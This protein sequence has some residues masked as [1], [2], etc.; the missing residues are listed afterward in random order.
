MI[1]IVS[2]LRSPPASKR[3]LGQMLARSC[4]VVEQ[5]DRAVLIALDLQLLAVVDDEARLVRIARR[6]VDE[7]VDDDLVSLAVDHR[8]GLGRLRRRSTSV[9]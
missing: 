9:K 2:G 3:A 7:I 5:R 8:V 6:P 1:V 4:A